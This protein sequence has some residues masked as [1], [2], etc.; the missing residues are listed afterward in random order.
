[1]LKDLIT[2]AMSFWPFIQTV[3]L[4]TRN[5]LTTM[6]KHDELA[7]EID[8]LVFL[9]CEAFHFTWSI[10]IAVITSRTEQVS[11]VSAAR[12]HYQNTLPKYLESEEI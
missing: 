12:N 2:W 8:I 9:I 10:C 6:R 11:A 4:F 3:M 5:F 7:V 1:M